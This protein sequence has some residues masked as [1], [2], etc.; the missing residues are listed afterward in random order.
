MEDYWE[1]MDEIEYWISKGIL[2]DFIL[3]KKSSGSMEPK[4]QAKEVGPSGTNE[5]QTI[6]GGPTKED[7]NHTRKVHA[8][9]LLIKQEVF[10][11]ALSQGRGK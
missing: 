7:S 1:L 10:R 8:R 11:I 3:A 9:R 2:K 4:N 6:L 5:V